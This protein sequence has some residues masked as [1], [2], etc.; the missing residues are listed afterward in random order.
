MVKYRIHLYLWTERTDQTIAP[1]A[2]KAKNLGFDGI[3]ILINS[4][5][6]TILKWSQALQQ[7]PGTKLI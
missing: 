2:S 3:E 1:F 6:L 4:I 7:F 5:Y